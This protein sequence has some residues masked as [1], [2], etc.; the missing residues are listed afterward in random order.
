MRYLSDGLR[1]VLTGLGNMGERGGNRYAYCPLDQS[2][3]DAAYRGSGLLRKVI[4]IPAFDMTREWRDWQA[5]ADQI[6]LLEAEEERLGIQAKVK[7]CEVLR[8]LGGGA[9]ILGAPGDLGMPVNA[10]SMAKQGLAFVHVT[11]RWQLIL[12]EMV[13]DLNDPLYGGPRYFQINTAQFGQQRLHPS[14]VICFKGDPI[15]NIVGTTWEDAFWG[16]G[17]IQRVLDAV[18]NSDTAQQAFA[19]L[20]VKTKNTRIGVSRLLDIVATTEGEQKMMARLSVMAQAESM[21]NWT[22]TDTG[23]GEGK[24]GETITDHQMTWAGIPDVMYAFATFVA[25]VADIPVTRL[26]GRAAEG[27]NS[28]G[29]SQQTDWNKMVSARQKL[30]LKPCLD[31]LDVAL[32]PSALGSRP[33]ELWWKFAPLDTPTEAEEATRFKTTVEAMSGVQNMG[34]I[35]HVAFA[36]ASQ[37]TLIEN[38]W[39]PGLDSALDEVPE[40]ER[41]GEEPEP[42]AGEEDP[43]AI[44]QEPKQA[45]N[46][47][48]PRTLYVSRKVVNVS[49]LKV[50]AK[51]QGLP[52]LQDDLHV[53]IVYSR[54]PL[55]WM[56]VEGEWNQDEKGQITIQPG[57]VR[58]VEPLGDRTA[59]LLFTSSSLTWRHEQIVRAGASHDYPDYQPHISL[60]G[61]PVDLAG[62]EPYR[63]KIVLGPEVFEEL[64]DSGVE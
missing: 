4:D 49:D 21:Y 43:S 18:T 53:T 7:Q 58:I 10:R 32:I 42:I 24:G 46:D 2:Q 25:A 20:I 17:R 33:P 11:S 16:E 28:S 48:A 22:L 9:L 52:E 35:P 40:S 56:K 26:L 31:Q 1:N 59:V 45:A 55:D 50:W 61:E 39:L 34:T 14:R 19:S 62:V 13:D 51:G 36:K 44:T 47:A 57:G 63:G 23:D 29:Q 60:T 37:N 27:M 12:G 6:E 54:Q 3:I 41:Y 8:G 64:Q 5:D 38:G 15:P 30:E